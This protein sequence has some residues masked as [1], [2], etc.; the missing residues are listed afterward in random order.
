MSKALISIKPQHTG[1]LWTKVRPTTLSFSSRQTIST[2]GILYDDGYNG[3]CLSTRALRTAI[4]RSGVT[5]DAVYL[6]ACLMNCVEALYELNE[7][8]PYIVSATYYTPDVGGEY[9]YLVKRLAT[10][11][12]YEQALAG[13]CDDVADYWLRCEEAGIN[14]GDYKA[15]DINAISS[16]QLR[17]AAPALKAF[18]DQLTQDYSDPQLAQKIDAVSAKALANETEYPL[19]DLCA[20][21]D[22][23]M[24][25]VPSTALADAARKAKDGMMKSKLNSR[26]TK[27][28]EERGLPTFNFLF[29]ANGS[30]EKL[31][32]DGENKRLLEITKYN[33]NGTMQTTK[34]GADGT[35][36][37]QDEGTWGSTGDDTYAQM[38]FDKLTG[39][40]RW[41]KMNR[42]KPLSQYPK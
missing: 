28:T 24:V 5:L 41:L 23:L 37:S 13:Y 3:L 14:P 11:A 36:T 2:A 27:A 7:V 8:T 20:Y 1:L 4:E 21:F 29:G 16:D 18:I 19:Y 12:N 26:G 22:S 6:D 33:W 25:N 32:L 30:W 17:S 9:S 40:N 34:Y 42:Q 31:K 39:W 35:V 10:S 15:S 38:N